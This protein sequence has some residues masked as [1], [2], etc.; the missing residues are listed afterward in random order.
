MFSSISQHLGLREE[1]VM[2]ELGG[3]LNPTVEQ[4]KPGKVGIVDRIK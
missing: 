3:K 4:R 1:E 2:V